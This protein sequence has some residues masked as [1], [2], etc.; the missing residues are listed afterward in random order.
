MTDI[1]IMVVPGME[2]C[3]FCSQK[4]VVWSYHVFPIPV[5][6]GPAA[7][8]DDWAACARCKELVDNDQRQSLLDRSISFVATGSGKSGLRQALGHVHGQ[9]FDVKNGPGIAV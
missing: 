6:L 1:H 3:D 9:F 4:P 8:N 5:T 2:V 7:T